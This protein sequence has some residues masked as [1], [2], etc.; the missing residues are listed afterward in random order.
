MV[1]VGDFATLAGAS[2]AVGSDRLRQPEVEHL[3][4]AVS[5]DLD[6]RGFQIAMND[7][8]L[9]R[10]FER[11]R[12]LLGDG[13]R[14]IERNGAARDALRQILAFDEFHHQRGHVAAIFNAV[15]GGDVG[16]IQRREHFRFALKTREPIGIRRD[17][18]G[19]TFR[20]TCRLSFVS[21]A[22]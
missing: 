17:R 20:A 7:A 10:R 19:R 6:V 21:V 13:Q 16:M 15:D 5:S 8:L 4:G 11:L 9:V 14:L 18:R 3:H 2:H 1:I 22:R 12:D